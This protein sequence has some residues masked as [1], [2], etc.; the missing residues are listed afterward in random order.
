MLRGLGV[1]RRARLGRLLHDVST[2]CF[3]CDALVVCANL[4]CQ[5][6]RDVAQSLRI[7][8]HKLSLTAAFPTADRQRRCDLLEDAWLLQ[9]RSGDIDNGCLGMIR[10]RESKRNL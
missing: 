7:V 2:P 10:S 6:R 4:D 8:L 5:G 9:A 3:I 1:S